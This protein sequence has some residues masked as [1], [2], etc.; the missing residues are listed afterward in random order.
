LV[1]LSVGCGGLD[2]CVV[3]RFCVAE[4]EPAKDRW[5]S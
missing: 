5:R 1:L 4:V 3:W 2:G